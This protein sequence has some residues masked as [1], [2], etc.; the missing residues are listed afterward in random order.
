MLS[1]RFLFSFL[2]IFFSFLAFGQAGSVVTGIV[3]DQNGTV[4]S[5]ATVHVKGSKIGTLSGADGTF[6]ITVPAGYDSIEVS[7]IDLGIIT[8]S[9]TPKKNE[10]LIAVLRE[11]KDPLEAVIINAFGKPGRSFM[12]KV[13]A[14]KA[15][16]NPA[17]LNSYSYRRYTRNELDLDNINFAT[18]GKGLKSMMLNTYAAADTNAKTD[19]EL[20]FYFAETIGNVYY[21]ISPSIET[22]TVIAKKNLGLQTDKLV[23][24]L[25]KFYFQFNVYDDW[26]PIFDQSYVSPL[27]SKAF[28]Y[29]KFIVADTLEEDGIQLQKVLFSPLKA[30]EKSFS[31]TMWINTA[32]LAVETVNM[33]LNSSANLNFIKDIVYSEDYKQVYDS[34]GA[35]SLVYMPYRF[36]SDIKFE[37]GAA[38]IGLPVK[39]KKQSLQF[40]IRNTTVND[41]I[42]LNSPSQKD[43]VKEQI[44]KEQDEVVN[45]NEDFWLKNRPD[46]LTEHEKNIYEMVDSLKTNK[47]FQRGIKLIAFAGS[48]YWDFHNKIRV[49]PYSSFISS[50]LVEGVRIRAGFSTLPG[51]SKK[52]NL[53]GYCAYGTKDKKIKGSLGAKYVWNKARWTKTSFAFGSDYNFTIDDDDEPDG[54]NLI[55]SFL[56]KNI[57]YTRL[58]VKQA[59]LKHEQYLNADLS[60]TAS[61]SYRELSP[62]FNFF[63]RPIDPL[64]DKPY[65]NVLAGALPVSEAT[66]GLRYV[67]KERTAILNYDRVRLN[68]YNPILTADYT[69][70]FN[71]GTAT[72]NFHKVNVGIEKL[73]RLP[74]KSLLFYKLQAGKFLGT[75]PYLLLNIPSGN[76]YYVSGRYQFNTMIPYEFVADKYLSLHSRFYPGGALLEKIPL[77]QKLGWRERFSFNAYWG[78]VSAGNAGYNKRA[79]FNTTTKG[80]FIE[81]G[82]GIENIFHVIS[83]EYYR[84]LSY[85]HNPYAKKGGV[86]LGV[87]LSF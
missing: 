76:E 23:S 87:T 33:H 53:Y 43:I 50:N 40:I 14:A 15:V 69:Y 56:R 13:I 80:P 49:G 7:H 57:P 4:V 16:N 28:N 52:L 62:V 86:F 39:N 78:G 46:S 1:R 68:T 70:G 54:D 18:K 42:V 60:L 84:R 29:Y 81:A 17:R 44:K 5:S 77:L 67:H 19:R 36:S 6:K 75:V 38:L 21:S 32:N 22:E 83:I 55:N 59:L 65:T 71:N 72:F 48:G 51:I 34:T 9:A 31:G 2:L 20:P 30:F 41:R 61:L 10:V 12:E 74:P 37:N 58:Y 26:I 11:N 47:K 85:L 35:G 79:G 82:A 3:K 24:G 64:S 45:T 25:S 63:Y 66:I 73:Q 27:N 8:L